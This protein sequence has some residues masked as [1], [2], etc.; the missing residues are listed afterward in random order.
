[1]TAKHK[2]SDRGSTGARLNARTPA[3]L[4]AAVLTAADFFFAGELFFLKQPAPDGKG[5]GARAERK[6]GTDREGSP[7]QP[8]C[9]GIS[10]RKKNQK[11]FFGATATAF[12]YF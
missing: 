4:R 5:R 10:P 6:R 7:G 9:G 2:P 3:L 12:Y 11:Y 1:M 8:V